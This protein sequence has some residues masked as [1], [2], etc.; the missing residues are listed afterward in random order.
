MSR[1]DDQLA[2]DSG[3]SCF[4]FRFNNSSDKKIKSNNYQLLCA[5]RL[6]NIFGIIFAETS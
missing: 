2:D 3:M 6:I 4:H 1:F 5:G